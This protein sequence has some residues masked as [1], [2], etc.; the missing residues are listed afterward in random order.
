MKIFTFYKNFVIIIFNTFF[1][2][3]HNI[4]K[5]SFHIID[6]ISIRLLK[7]S[8]QAFTNRTIVIY[9]PSLRNRAREKKLNQFDDKRNV[10]VFFCLILTKLISFLFIHRR[11]PFQHRVIWEYEKLSRKRTQITAFV[12]VI[13][14]IIWDHKKF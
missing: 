14:I 10:S 6:L 11:N 2:K 12:L 7:C 5:S 8:Q 9:P 13:V 3:Q 4:R 1:T